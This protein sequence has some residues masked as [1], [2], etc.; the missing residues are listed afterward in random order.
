MKSDQ[1]L[2]QR[3]QRQWRGHFVAGRDLKSADVPVE[4]VRKWKAEHRRKKAEPR[5]EVAAQGSDSV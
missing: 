5:A 1:Y 3:G 2:W 4:L